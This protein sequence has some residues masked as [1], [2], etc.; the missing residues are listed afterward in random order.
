MEVEYLKHNS[1]SAQDALPVDESVHYS[2]LVYG[3]GAAGGNSAAA[4]HVIGGWGHGAGN[5]SANG[6]LF[7]LKGSDYGNGAAN[8][9]S[10]DSGVVYG[11]GVQQENYRGGGWS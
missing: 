9:N 4:P 10:H 3:W 7:A 2:G 5:S 1:L 8:G 11:N 6:V